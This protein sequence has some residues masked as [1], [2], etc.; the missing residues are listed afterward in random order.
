MFHAVP[1]FT[2]LRAPSRFGLVVVFVLAVLSAIALRR[3]S[4]RAGPLACARGSRASRS[5][6]W[7]SS[8]SCRFR[9]SARCRSP[10]NYALLARDA[11]RAAW[12]SSRSTA[13]ASRIPLHAQYMV[14]STAHWMPLI[15]GYSDHIPDDFRQAAFVLDSFPVER[16]LRGAAETPRALRRRPL[17]H[18]RAAGGGNP[19]PARAVRAPPPIARQRRDDDAVR[20]RVVP[21]ARMPVRTNQLFA[22]VAGPES[23]IGNPRIL[24]SGLGFSDSAARDG[25]GRDGSRRWRSCRSILRRA[26]SSAGPSS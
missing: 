25:S 11:A 19:H 16:R 1:L 18:V 20:D 17:G 24:E 10:R 5:R 26:P 23:L 15:N 7:R 14:F 3:L 2:F 9:G 4:A 6:P 12:P 8:T 21:V 13:S 22:I